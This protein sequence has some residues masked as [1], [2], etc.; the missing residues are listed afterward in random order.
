M[1]VIQVF[2]NQMFVGQTFVDQMFVDQMFVGQMVV[3]EKKWSRWSKWD[4]LSFCRTKWADDDEET[5]FQSKNNKVEP[6]D[7]F[8]FR[9]NTCI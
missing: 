4:V 6:N 1:F 8:V 3:D 7:R 9:E 2:V 5:F